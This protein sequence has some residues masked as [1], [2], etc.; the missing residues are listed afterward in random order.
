MAEPFANVLGVLKVAHLFQTE[1]Y[2]NDGTAVCLLVCL[3]SCACGRMI[4]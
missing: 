4:S 1:Y 3:T 2:D